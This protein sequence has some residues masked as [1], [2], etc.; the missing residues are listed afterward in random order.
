MPNGGPD[1]CGNCSHNIAVQELAHPQPTKEDEFWYLSCCSLR[2]LNITNPFWT[3]CNNFVYG[4]NPELRNKSEEIKGTITSSGLYEGYVRIP[5]NKNNEPYV[6]VPTTCFICSLKVK[7]GIEV[8][9]YN[10]K[11]GFCTN[12]HYVKWW[13]SVNDDKSFSPD[14]YE[15]PKDLKLI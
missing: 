4:K 13:V 12:K 10:N 8:K 6:G 11:L 15:D 1:C 9:H 5:W 14:D 3:Y 2:D 7:S